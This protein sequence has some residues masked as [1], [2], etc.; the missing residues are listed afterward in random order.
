[1]DAAAQRKGTWWDDYVAWLGER[2]GDEKV[3]P[4]KLGGKGLRPL[5]PAPGTYVR[6][7]T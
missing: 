5:E 2:S 1:M 6:E 3:A 4:K 7:G